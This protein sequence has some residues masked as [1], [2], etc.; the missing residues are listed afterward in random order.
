MNLTQ[1]QRQQKR[2]PGGQRKELHDVLFGV[3]QAYALP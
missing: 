2:R 3:R 1:G